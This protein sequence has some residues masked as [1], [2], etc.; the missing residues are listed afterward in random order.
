METVNKLAIGKLFLLS[1]A[2]LFMIAQ[3]LMAFQ[4][5][6]YGNGD[7]GG[8][9]LL[10][11]YFYIFIYLFYQ[12]Y[13]WA[14]WVLSISLIL[15]SI[16]LFLAGIENGSTILKL[17][18]IYYLYFGVIPHFSLYLKSLT[19]T[20][21]S[22]QEK[23]QQGDEGT[24]LVN[25]T[26]Y[27]YPLLLKRYQA[28]FIDGWIILMGAILSFTLMDGN[29]NGQLILRILFLIVLFSY[30]PILTTYATTIG[31]KLTGIRVR[32]MS[33]PQRSIS[34][35]KAYVRFF[36][37]GIL[38]WLSFVTIHF[39]PHHRAIHDFMSSSVVIKV[40]TR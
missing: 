1:L 35:A 11:G 36:T 12:G 32:E 33:N 9:L 15:F 3:V 18:A 7:I 10:T 2:L 19:Q 37:K 17:L 28:L 30:E 20:V 26:I 4:I 8:F 27:E 25:S 5:L 16:V 14:K 39:N 6:E 29:E 23:V 21:L 24:F 22:P 13:V 40:K 38:G 34:L 31:Q